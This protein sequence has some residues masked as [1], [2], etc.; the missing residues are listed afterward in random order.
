MTLRLFKKLILALALT[1]ATPAMAQQ[2]AIDDNFAWS[3]FNWDGNGRTL[4]VW[5]PIL[6][7]GNIAI[8][9]AFSARGGQKYSNLS[10]QAIRDMRID[11]PNG[12]FIRNL[13]FLAQRGTAGYDAR[14]KGEMAN[15]RVTEIA[16][17]QESLRT[18]KLGFTPQRYRY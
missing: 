3:T 14:L 8:C 5:R 10:R 4:V 9:G 16:G 7:E 6:I 13:S 11:G 1:A 15:C 12:A 2:V 18:F 17:T